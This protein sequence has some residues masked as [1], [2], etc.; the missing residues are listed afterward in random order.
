MFTNGSTSNLNRSNLM[1][2]LYKPFRNYMRQF[3]RAGSLELLWAYSE[4]IAN[5]RQLPPAMQFRDRLG[6]PSTKPLQVYPWEIDLLAREIVLN[7]NVAG[8]RS[9]DSWQELSTVINRLRHLENEISARHGSPDT[10]LRDLHRVVHHQFPWQR[11]PSTRS[12]MRAYKLFGTDAMRA[13]LEETTGVPLDAFFRLG[14][15]CAGHFLRDPGLN[16]QQD[17]AILDVSREAAATFFAR[18]TSDMDALGAAARAAQRYDDSWS[19]A[20]NPLRALPLVGS[21]RRIPNACC[22]RSLPS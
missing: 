16:T 11:P 19:Y 6:Q 8:R 2:D 12:M 5:G 10:I 15:A 20:L 9:L 21:T 4:H 13:I 3:P 18:L 17:Y 7:D 1:H 22:V 14:M